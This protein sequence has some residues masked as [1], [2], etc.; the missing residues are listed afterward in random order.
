MV[1]AQISSPCGNSL[2]FTGP[3]TSEL[4]LNRESSLPGVNAQPPRHRSTK[5]TFEMLGAPATTAPE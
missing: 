1:S 2:K 3:E 4:V 5:T